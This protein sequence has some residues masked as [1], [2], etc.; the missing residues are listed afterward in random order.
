VHYRVS[1]VGAQHWRLIRL[2]NI[3][4]ARFDRT[5]WW[6][7]A[8]N[9][10]LATEDVVMCGNRRRFEYRIVGFAL[11]GAFVTF[12]LSDYLPCRVM[13]EPVKGCV[14]KTLGSTTVIQCSYSR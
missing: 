8:P 12:Y 10:R 14:I 2:G 7:S 11:V 3:A 1:H 5:H 13:L 4:V 6:Y 9:L